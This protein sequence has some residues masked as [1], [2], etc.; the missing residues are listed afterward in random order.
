M[1]PITKAE[2]RLMGLRLKLN[3]P[4]GK[5][6]ITANYHISRMTEL[7]EVFARRRR[8]CT[9]NEYDNLHACFEDEFNVL[10][11]EAIERLHI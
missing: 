3:D 2:H 7:I 4:T 6:S 1:T 5:V 10:Y 9:K 8:I 11:E